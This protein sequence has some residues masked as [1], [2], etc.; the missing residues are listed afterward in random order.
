MFKANSRNTKKRCE[1]CSKLKRH[2]TDAI[3][4]VLVLYCYFWIYFTPCS[5]V[6]IVKFEQVIAR[7]VDY[8]NETPLTHFWPMFPFYTPWK[9]LSSWLF[10]VY[11]IRTSV[12]NQL[13]M[14]WIKRFSIVSKLPSVETLLINIRNKLGAKP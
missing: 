2:Q 9:P 7:W 4:V 1:I 8:V 13:T 12:R 10:R 3:D 6:S 5:S 14:I 11:N